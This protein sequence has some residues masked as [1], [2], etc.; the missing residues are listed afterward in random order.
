MREKDDEEEKEQDLCECF[1]FF[2]SELLIAR[3]QHINLRRAQRCAKI[4][5]LDAHYE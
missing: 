2:F 4:L 1:F 3:L 5:E